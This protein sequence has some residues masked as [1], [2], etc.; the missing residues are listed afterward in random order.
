[1][2]VYWSPDAL[3]GSSKLDCAEIAACADIAGHILDP[4]PRIFDFYLIRTTR[5]WQPVEPKIAERIAH[6]RRDFL[7]ITP[8]GHMRT[9]YAFIDPADVT[10]ERSPN[11]Q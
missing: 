10:C 9:G 3:S 5:F 7:A 1:M 6:G 8:Q 2:F 11:Q 4:E